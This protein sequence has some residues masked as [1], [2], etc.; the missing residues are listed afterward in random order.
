[1]TSWCR[2]KEYN[3]LHTSHSNK[4]PKS[5]P[6]LWCSGPA[7][8]CVWYHNDHVLWYHVLPCPFVLHGVSHLPDVG[9][10]CVIQFACYILSFT[11]LTNNKFATLNL[12]AFRVIFRE[13]IWRNI[14][15]I[16]E[17]CHSREINICI[18]CH[19]LVTMFAFLQNNYRLP[20]K[21][22][23]LSLSLFAFSWSNNPRAKHLGSLNVKKKKMNNFFD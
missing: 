3:L 14:S 20:R 17:I 15:T 4:C 5:W 12:W 2:Y 1:V 11:L 13:N 10:N 16:H 18:I 6:L 7:Y 21:A 23:W 9:I 19:F 22:S 8:S